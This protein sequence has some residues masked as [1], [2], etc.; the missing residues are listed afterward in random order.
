[1]TKGREES[2]CRGVIGGKKFRSR[3]DKTP[4]STIIPQT[5]YVSS[6][7]YFRTIE[8]GQETYIGIF[9]VGVVNGTPTM[10]ATL[11]G[12]IYKA[13]KQLLSDALSVTTNELY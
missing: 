6:L 4:T 9:S 8:S 11:H 7:L 10:L 13:L 1:M 5:L 2:I 3:E 12:P